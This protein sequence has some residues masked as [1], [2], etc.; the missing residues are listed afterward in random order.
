M[1]RDSNVSIIP[2][3]IVFLGIVSIAGII[4]LFFQPKEFAAKQRTAP[5]TGQEL[6]A[7]V[8][9]EARASL[10]SLWE[11]GDRFL[12]GEALNC[13]DE[14]APDPKIGRS[15]LQCQPHFWQCYWQG[16]VHAKPQLKVDFFGQ[17]YHVSAR[18]SFNGR[19]YRPLRSGYLVELEVKELPGL[20]RRVVLPDSCRD[21]YLPERIYGYGRVKNRSEEGFIWD[22]FGRRIFIDKYYVTNQKINEWRLLTGQEKQL[23]TDPKQWPYPARLNRKEQK[24]YCAYYGK[25]LLEAKLFDAASMPPSSLKDPTPNRIS[26]PQTP[27]QRDLSK[28]FLGMAR[29][30]PDFQLT[31]LDCQLG[32]VQGCPE[33][34]FTTD[35][36]SWMGM[37]HVLGFWPESLN[38]NIEPDKNLKLSS[39]FLPAHSEAHELGIRGKWSGVQSSES[40]TIAFRCYEEVAP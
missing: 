20:S 29:I 3:I 37:N 27:W 24:D 12:G 32:Q 13:P 10:L 34:H 28:T 26:R 17:T 33:K 31:P 18:P 38:N 1:N 14:I 6:F 2:K 22:N 5:S 15:Y 7:Q 4:L 9:L 8:L 35:S 19:Y 36:V 25:R 30:N 40:E 16:G 23:I 11:E 21:V 39:R